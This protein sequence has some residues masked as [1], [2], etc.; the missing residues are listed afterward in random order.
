MAQRS[1]DEIIAVDRVYEGWLSLFL[2][3]VRLSGEERVRPLIEHPSGSAILAYDPERCV[4]FTV[5]QTRLPVLH[6]GFDRLPEPVAGANERESPEETA[7]RECKEEIGVELGRVERVGTVW[8]TPSSSTER[9]DL[10]LGEYRASSRVEEGGG[11]EGELEDLDI[12]E[13]PLVGL[14]SALAASTM[15]DAKLFMLLQALRL[16]R[17]ELFRAQSTREPGSSAGISDR[18]GRD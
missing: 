2:A 6:L 12:R 14:W 8:M 9:V 5:R 16:R 18:P 11:A 4:A 15:T 13:E 1:S 7:R 3:K 10:F 17:P